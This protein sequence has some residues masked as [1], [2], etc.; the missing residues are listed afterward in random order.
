MLRHCSD[1]NFC[2][3]LNVKD[4]DGE[5]FEALDF[6]NGTSRQTFPLPLCHLILFVWVMQRVFISM[7]RHCSDRNFCTLL[8]VK[9]NDGEHF[10][11]LDFPPDCPATCYI[12]LSC[13]CELC[14]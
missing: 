9:D 7:L 6:P 10:E 5:H 14:E 12:T 2:T 1:R 11:A 13:L 4:N 3:L 8:N